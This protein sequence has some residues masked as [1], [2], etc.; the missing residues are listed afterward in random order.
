MMATRA[1]MIS[2]LLIDSVADLFVLGDS[3]ANLLIDGVALL[4]I[5]SLA[6]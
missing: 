5:H 6:N 4:L 2:Y 1:R 3:V